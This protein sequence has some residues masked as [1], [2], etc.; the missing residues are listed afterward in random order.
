MPHSF[1]LIKI[2]LSLLISDQSKYLLLSNC[3]FY[4]FPPCLIVHFFSHSCRLAANT[5]PLRSISTTTVL[6]QSTGPSEFQSG[7]VI[8]ST[9]FDVFEAE[10]VLHF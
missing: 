7:A 2:L 6:S 9:L 10:E 4:G 1:G 8:V 3:I 5:S